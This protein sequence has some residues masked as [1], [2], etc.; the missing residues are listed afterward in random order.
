MAGRKVGYI[1]R[2]ES[3]LDDSLRVN[4]IVLGIDT[5]N[6]ISPPAE[7]DIKFAKV[8]LIRDNTDSKQAKAIEVQ[9]NATTRANEVPDEPIIYDSENITNDRTTSD[10]YSAEALAVDDVVEITSYD[11]KSDLLQWMVRQSG[12]GTTE[13]YVEIVGP[14]T[15]DEVTLQQYDNPVDLNAVGVPFTAIILGIDFGVLPNTD[16]GEGDW[17]TQKPDGNYYFVPSR[18]YG[19]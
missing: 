11:D 17:I 12:G 1:Y 6:S 7:N 2:K 13:I 18:F 19:S 14:N 16:S 4:R 15:K 8:T 10:I 5:S 9:Y 3:D